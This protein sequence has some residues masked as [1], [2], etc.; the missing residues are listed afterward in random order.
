MVGF[1]VTVLF[2]FLGLEVAVEVWAGEVSG[3]G[4]LTGADSSV[5]LQV[6]TTDKMYS[7]KL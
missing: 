6:V 5:R 3:L 1:G 4:V 7:Y 2:L